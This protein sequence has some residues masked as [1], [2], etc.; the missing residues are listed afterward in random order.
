MTSLK[1][2]LLEWISKNAEVK[3]ELCFCKRCGGKIMASFKTWII[4]GKEETV[5][6]PFCPNC[7]GNAEAVLSRVLAAPCEKAKEC[8]YASP[9]CFKPV[10]YNPS[11][12]SAIPAKRWTVCSGWP[13]TLKM[14]F[15]RISGRWVYLSEKTRRKLDRLRLY[16]DESYDEIVQRLL[17]ERES[18]EPK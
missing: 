11:V 15:D 8:R 2:L 16:P 3:G 4:N 13:M 9:Q 6:I 1:V 5:A 18:L 17:K 7:D 12:D 10:S 14:H